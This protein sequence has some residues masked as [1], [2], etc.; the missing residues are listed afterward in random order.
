[1]LKALNLDEN[2]NA[3]DL[4]KAYEAKIADIDSKI[5]Q[6]PTEALK[7]KFTKGKG[8]LN[9]AYQLI[10]EEGGKSSSLL[11]QTQISDLPQAKASYTN[12]GESGEP[13][14][15]AIRDGDLLAERYEV[16]E[17]IGSGGMGVVYRAFDRNRQREIAIKVLL[18]NFVES[19]LAKERFLN[20]G[21]ISS[22]L[23]HPNILNV[24]DVQFDG[25]YAF[26]T[27]ELLQGQSLRT[28]I[29]QRKLVRK[30]Y[31]VKELNEVISPLCDA[32]EYAHRTTIH[33]DIKPENIWIGSD[34]T[35]KL[36]DFG[37][38]RVISD[39]KL[40]KT[41]VAIGSA[42]YMAPEQA[43]GSADVGV[44]AD[45]YSVAVLIYEMLSLEVPIGR[46]LPI[47]EI[48]KTVHTAFSDAVDRAMSIKESARYKDI[49]ALKK[50]LTSAPETQV[51]NP[52]KRPVKSAK[53]KYTAWL[54]PP[55]HEDVVFGGIVMLPFIVTVASTLVVAFTKQSLSATDALICLMCGLLVWSSFY[56]YL[57]EKRVSNKARNASVK[58]KFQENSEFY[59]FPIGFVVLVALSTLEWLYKTGIQL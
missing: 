24:Y 22:D 42:Y 47:K 5:E 16:K 31:T 3:D 49:K 4:K 36:M 57:R 37:I 35:V 8:D 2:A 40:T 20:E 39:D 48:N 50:V 32:L 14:Q 58:E 9:Y 21:R 55:E 23:S 56:I 1:M 51:K 19:S 38:A 11:S 54:K 26:I 46:A 28:L 59:L 17:Q 41:G 15:L 6:A 10:E 45:Q 13:I 33:R 29:E 43:N 7:Q 27:M 44:K 12:F 34:G 53:D 52:K 30:R 18:P 25:D